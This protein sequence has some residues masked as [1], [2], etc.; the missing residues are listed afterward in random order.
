MDPV[1]LSRRKAEEGD[2]RASVEVRWYENE[3]VFVKGRAGWCQIAG[4][5]MMI[6]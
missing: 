4:D 5:G 6:L 2:E 3:K 1:I